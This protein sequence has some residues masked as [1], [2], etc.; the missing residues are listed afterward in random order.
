VPFLSDPRLS[1]LPI[2]H[3]VRLRLIELALQIH[4]QC[5]RLRYIFHA[6]P[7]SPHHLDAF[8][9]LEVRLLLRA[10]AE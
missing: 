7:L 3:Y 5:D 6:T 4:G 9:A 2:K 8:R 1:S 10:L